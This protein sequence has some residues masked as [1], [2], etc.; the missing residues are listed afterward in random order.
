MI[1]TRKHWFILR[2]SALKGNLLRLRFPGLPFSVFILSSCFDLLVLPTSFLALLAFLIIAFTFH[3]VV[4]YQQVSVSEKAPSFWLIRSN[5][6]K[7][8]FKYKTWVKAKYHDLEK[9]NVDTGVIFYEH[10]KKYVIKFREGEQMFYFCNIVNLQPVEM[11]SSDKKQV[12]KSNKFQK[13]TW[14]YVQAVNSLK[15]QTFASFRVFS[16]K[17][18]TLDVWNERIRGTFYSRNLKKVLFSFVKVCAK[19]LVHFFYV[20]GRK[21]F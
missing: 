14:Y 5:K 20:M 2:I 21:R 17:F 7:A 13:P 15:A 10:F 19:I 8:N 16:R 6:K 1:L 18:I 12:K 3:S 4:W 11:R 9:D